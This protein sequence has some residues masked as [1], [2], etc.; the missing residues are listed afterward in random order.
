MP[1]SQAAAVATARLPADEAIVA[2]PFGDQSLEIEHGPP[3]AYGAIRGELV[4]VLVQ[5]A[6][7]VERVRGC[8]SR[9]RPKLS[10]RP[11]RLTTC[12]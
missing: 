1:A 10:A 4:I 12:F 5:G 7:C 9:K 11:A 8:L 2:A 3:F 6:E